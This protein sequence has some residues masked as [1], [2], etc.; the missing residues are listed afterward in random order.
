MREPREQEAPE[1]A[2]RFWT[3]DTGAGSS[4][5]VDQG[6]APWEAAAS[7][8]EGALGFPLLPRA[9]CDLLSVFTSAFGSPVVSGIDEVMSTGRSSDLQLS[10]APSDLSR[11]TERTR[12]LGRTGN[13]TIC[14]K[15]NLTSV[16]L[17][18]KL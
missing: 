13:G 2:L 11:R 12:L 18:E 15:E 4:Q 14:Q 9:A 8:E 5:M 16:R 17:S 10:A 6:R 7:G 1:T 3:P